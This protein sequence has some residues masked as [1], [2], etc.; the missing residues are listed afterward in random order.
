MPTPPPLQST[1]DRYAKSLAVPHGL[2]QLHDRKKHR[3]TQPQMTLAPAIVLT[4]V[5][6][7]EGFVEE[8]N[9]VIG[10]IR[11]LSFAQIVR[12][13]HTNS[14]SLGEFHNDLLKQLAA[15][16]D[17]IWKKGFSLEVFAAPVP[18]GTNWWKRTDIG[19]DEAVKQAE[20]WLQVRHSLIHGLTRGYLT[21][22][23]PGPMRVGVHA[24]YVLREYVGSRHSLSLHSAINCARILRFGAESLATQ[25][26]KTLGLKPPNWRAVPTFPL[27][28]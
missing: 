27:D 21:E 15:W 1:V 12:I 16:S 22:V 19:W 14:P 26:A 23:W 10:G 7:F 20:A 18:G 9:A 28:A 13:A 17:P 2:Q 3:P 5:A 11:G 6:A 4:S 24:N 8:F 25:S